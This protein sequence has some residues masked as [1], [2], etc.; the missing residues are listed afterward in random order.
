MI[1]ECS[2]CGGKVSTEAK[3]CMQCGAPPKVPL[4]CHDCGEVVPEGATMCQ[5]C[6]APVRVSAP[7][8][9]PVRVDP[10]RVDPVRVDP[11]RVDP[12]RVDSPMPT[13]GRVQETVAPAE[14]RESLDIGAPSSSVFK[15]Y[16][17][18]SGRISRKTF[19]IRF[20]ILILPAILLGYLITLP[21]AFSNF[22]GAVFCLVW[23]LVYIP[24]SSKRLHD[25]NMAGDWLWMPA[26]LI[27]FMFFLQAILVP[28]ILKGGDAS[29]LGLVSSIIAI[30][31]MVAS[32]VVY[33]MMFFRR[34]TYDEPNRY[35]SLSGVAASVPRATPPP[36]DFRS[37]S[38]AIGQVRS[39]PVQVLPVAPVLPPKV[40]SELDEKITKA[41]TQN[42][43]LTTLVAVVSIFVLV[44]LMKLVSSNE[45]IDRMEASTRLL[46][47][48][49]LTNAQSLFNAGEPFPSDFFDLVDKSVLKS[50]A[51]KG[52]AEAQFLWGRVHCNVKGLLKD[53][54]EAV[55]WYRKAAVQGH[56]GAQYNLG[57]CYKNGQGVSKDNREAAK[58]F[59]K[60]AEQGGIDAQYNLGVFYEKGLGVS[61]NEHEA[62]KWY[63]KAAWQGHEGAR[64]AL[65]SSE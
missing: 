31:V 5:V 19:A 58:W 64:R 20:A 43:A 29:A 45:S 1:I 56:V 60:A 65:G 6:G 21:I 25:M 24:I 48:A 34:G 3:A 44:G 2:E 49:V 18:C 33:G 28:F 11:V 4:A 12:V 10:V 38:D 37:T 52:S 15:D 47:D 7:R 53:D 50:L 8:V 57:V 61:K 30:V 51:E 22:A 39:N 62:A 27:G 13:Q 59:L 23:F 40:G 32:L 46:D 55:S 26:G 35:S 9:D 41:L 42:W 54:V 14:R 16:F 17:S 36:I 63:R